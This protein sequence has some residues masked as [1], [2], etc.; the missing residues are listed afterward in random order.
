MPRAIRKDEITLV[1]TGDVMLQ[2]PPRLT[3][4]SALRGL[5]GADVTFVNLEV[6]LTDRGAPQE[7]AVP[8]RAPTR[9][10]PAVAA[11][12]IHVATVANN[13]ALDY[14]EVGLFDTLES[15]R[16]AGV[17]AVGGG[18]NL[19]EAL[20]PAVWKHEA[21][22]L[23][24]AFLGLAST[25]PN[26]YGA[27][28]VRPGIAPVRVHTR[29]VLDPGTL[30]EQP[31]TA[32]YVETVANARDVKQACQEVAQAKRRAD[33][34]VV[35]IHWGV[36]YGFVAGVQEDLA[37]YQRPLGHALVDAGADLVVGH[38]PH[39]VHGVERYRRGVILYSLGNF[40]FH[41][42]AV[43]AKL[44]LTQDYPPYNWEGLKSVTARESV[45]A[46]VTL[47]RRGVRRI[48]FTPTCMDRSGEPEFITG[49]QAAAVLGRLAAYSARLGTRLRIAG[50]RAA[51]EM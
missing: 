21:S 31:G 15:L 4:R 11:A 34:V 27:T 43:G 33:L 42:L 17:L 9:V 46:T 16:R 23:R 8:L 35:G 50:G 40:L 38:H 26:S 13:H 7:K 6:P 14:G 29:Y 12:G 19:D 1:A 22:G 30:L 10:A 45:L 25:L 32:P 18:K 3:R 20:R 37:E 47:G 2:R 48:V 5:A 24:I 49:A 39:V 44:P 51:L 41:A 36:A 28:P